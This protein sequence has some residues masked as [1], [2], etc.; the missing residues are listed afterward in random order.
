MRKLWAFAL[1]ILWTL[2][3][4][5]SGSAQKSRH[6]IVVNLG[7]STGYGYPS[8][9]RSTNG[10]V[11]SLN[12]SGDY[13]LYD[14]LSVGLY[15]AYTYSFYKMKDQTVPG[16]EYKDIWRGWDVGVRSSFHFSP[17]ILENEKT[18]LYIAAFFGYSDYSLNFDKK[19]I[20]RTLYKYELRDI[21]AGS[22]AG[23]R[24]YLTKTI[25]LYAEAGLSRKFFL[26]AGAAINVNPPH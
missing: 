11:P 23:L 1:G 25:G 18:D 8:P 26:S 16:L 14:L 13:S 21:N 20:H 6:D 4:S 7:P 19:N 3:L 12:I 15:G 5:L 22:L 24:Y 2:L 9:F 10:R 17:L